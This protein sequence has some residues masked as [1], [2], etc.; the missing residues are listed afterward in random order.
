[1]PNKVK[2]L[3]KLKLALKARQHT[4]A[5]LDDL[6]TQ[7]PEVAKLKV[8]VMC[9]V[10]PVL[11]AVRNLLILKLKTTA[12]NKRDRRAKSL[13]MVKLF[14]CVE[15]NPGPEPRLTVTTAAACLHWSLP[16]GPRE[17]DGDSGEEQHAMHPRQR[18]CL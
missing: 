13:C 12:S 2:A 7:D 18:S 9:D 14:R 17:R 15:C 10:G 8:R 1:M 11:M 6:L 3:K 16:E 5:A 4:V